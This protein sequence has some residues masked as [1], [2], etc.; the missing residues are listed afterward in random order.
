VLV[1]RALAKA[2]DNRELYELLSRE[3]PSES[4]RQEFL[5]SRRE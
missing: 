1:N 3:I 5:K 2:A 4:E